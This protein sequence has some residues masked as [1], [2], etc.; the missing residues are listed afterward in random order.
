[1]WS[2]LRALKEFLTSPP[3]LT[4]PQP[5]KDLILYLAISE[6]AISLVIMIEE[7]KHQNLVCYIS[8]VLKNAKTRYQ[9]IENL[10]LALVTF[11]K[12]TKTIFSKSSNCCSNR[13]P[14][15]NNYE[16]TRTHRMNDGLVD[17]IVQVWAK[18]WIKGVNEVS[19]PSKICNQT[20]KQYKIG[21]QVVEALCRWLIQYK[22]EWG[23]S[24]PRKPKWSNSRAILEV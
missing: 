21:I 7:E 5:V 4:G 19:V 15:P 16:K 14:H 8:R 3:I 9:M 24:H 17:Q 23:W 20:N 11:S 22:R 6:H 2:P 10:V 12:N 1:M 18:I 13:P